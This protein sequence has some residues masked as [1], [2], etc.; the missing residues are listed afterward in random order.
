MEEHEENPSRRV[1][2]ATVRRRLEFP[3]EGEI[4]EDQPQPR[5][6]IVST[7]SRHSSLRQGIRRRTRNLSDAQIGE[8]L[9]DLWD[10]DDHPMV[11]GDEDSDF[12]DISPDESEDEYL[13]PGARRQ[14][15][16]EESEF[17]MGEDSEMDFSGFE[18]GDADDDDDDVVQSSETH[19]S[20]GV[21]EGDFGRGEGGVV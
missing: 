8:Y 5:V 15:R 6:A 1:I 16:G 9:N 20:A 7:P 21:S 18:H 4:P 19:E 14:A 11:P 12:D 17:G 3:E 10:R 2:G 13:P